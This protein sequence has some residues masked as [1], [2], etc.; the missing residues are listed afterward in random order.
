MYRRC[1]WKFFSIEEMFCQ[2]ASGVYVGKNDDLLANT[3]YNLPAEGF[4]CALLF[5]LLSI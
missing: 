2:K 5:P 4:L 1:L 3:G